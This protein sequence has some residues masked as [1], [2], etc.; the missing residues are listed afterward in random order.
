MSV[1]GVL[2]C[3]ILELEIAYLLKNDTR[4]SSLFVLNTAAGRGLINA[5]KTSGIDHFVPIDSFEAFVPPEDDSLSVLVHVLELGMHSRKSRL[6]KA[7]V[8]ETRKLSVHADALF[9][10]YG[11]CGNALSDP[12]VLLSHLDIPF[13]MPRDCDHPADDCV[14]MLIG[15]RQS[16]Y[17]EQIKEAGTFFMTPGWANHWNTIFENDHENMDLEMAK[18]MFKDYKRTLLIS[19][20]VME[21][22][23][24][25]ENVQDFN[26]LFNCYSELSQGSMTSLNDAWQAAITACTATPCKNHTDTETLRNT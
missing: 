1:L 18:R 14:G 4:I 5:L 10:G 2:T 9:F 13:F 21:D 15:G 26:R 17:D 24:M 22:R 19:T 23:Q 16:Y 3:E 12:E 6:Q 25:K 7:L 8:T 20:P 11:L